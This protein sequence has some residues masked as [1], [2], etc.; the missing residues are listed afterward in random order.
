[1]T[2]VLTPSLRT[3]LESQ[4]LA[5]YPREACGLLVGKSECHGRVHDVW[6]LPNRVADNPESSFAMDPG[7]LVAALGRAEAAGLEQ[8]GFWHSHPDAAAIPSARDRAA[9]WPD[10][11]QLIASIG[12]RGLV[13]LR[14]WRMDPSGPI[15]EGLVT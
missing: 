6:S 2:L 9:A 15:E 8:V 1:M 14:G 7:E 4:A 10:S 13:E 3:K 11:L 12:A 5:A